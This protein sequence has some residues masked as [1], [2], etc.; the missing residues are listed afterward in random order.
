MGYHHNP[1][2][3]RR[4]W[5]APKKWLRLWRGHTPRP[6]PK[7]STHHAK[8]FQLETLIEIAPPVKEERAKVTLKTM[9]WLITLNGLKSGGSA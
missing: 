7:T 9:P 8:K 1:L 4:R 2:T 3:F 6:G 5:A